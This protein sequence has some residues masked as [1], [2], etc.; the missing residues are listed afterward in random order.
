MLSPELKVFLI[1]MSPIVEL[2][3]AIPLALK[4][5]GLSWWQTYLLAVGGNLVPLMAIVVSGRPLSDFLSQ[6]WSWSKRFFNWLFE[7]VRK[8]TEK[9]NKMGKEATVVVL[10]ALPVPLVGGWTGALAA[11]LL[12]LPRKRSAI[13]VS[14]GAAISGLIVTSLTLIL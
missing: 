7:K 1:A 6:H 13:L 4:V 14:L 9:L 2:R 10:T 12:G 5:Y 3:G 8:K 11:F